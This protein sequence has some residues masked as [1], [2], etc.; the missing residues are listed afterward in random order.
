MPLHLLC[1]F[2]LSLHLL[3]LLLLSLLLAR[4][5]RRLPLLSLLSLLSLLA[6]ICGRR[7]GPAPTS[8]VSRRTSALHLRFFNDIILHQLI[9]QLGRLDVDV[10]RIIHKSF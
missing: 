3:F 6:R 10:L 8:A 4:S 7:C 2:L 1:L 9:D 5:R